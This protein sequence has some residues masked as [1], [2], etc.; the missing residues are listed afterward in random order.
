MSG[1]S[2]FIDSNIAIYLL[3]GDT[4]ISNFLEGK[5]VCISFISE[6]ELLGYKN[7]ASDRKKIKAFLN[8]CEIIDINK[9]IKELT[10]QL[11]LKYKIKLPDAI[12]AA[13]SIHLSSLLMS[14]DN[15]FKS[16]EELNLA[17]YKK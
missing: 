10:I 1:N 8:G 7:N 17:L 6:I 9:D 15:D 16:I 13:S 12:V 11:R 2:I 3:D 14:A 5:N 4:T